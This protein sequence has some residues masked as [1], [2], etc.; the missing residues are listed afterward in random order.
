MSLL[1]K[2]YQRAFRRERILKIF[3][4][5]FFL[6][7]S[8]VL[9]GFVFMLPSYFIVVFSKDDVLRRLHSEEEVLSRREVGKLEAAIS[10]VNKTI[11][12]YESNEIR[13]RSF[14][15]LLIKV[16]MLTPQNIKILNI[17]LKKSK[18]VFLLDIAGNA[19]AR[20]DLLGYISTLEATPDFSEVLSPI[21]NLLEE[22]DI[23]FT[24]TLKIKPEVYKL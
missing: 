17:N 4:A 15:D 6:F 7:S 3:T 9:V 21:N 2:N 1:T 22:S 18:D 14:S 20:E 11:S 16:F 23:N 10:K 12:T 8:S 13:R 24:I 5:L 19:L